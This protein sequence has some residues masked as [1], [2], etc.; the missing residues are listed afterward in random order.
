MERTYQTRRNSRIVRRLVLMHQKIITRYVFQGLYPA[1]QVSAWKALKR[2]AIRSH[3]LHH[4]EE[5]Q[6][7]IQ[8]AVFLNMYMDKI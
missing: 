8:F 5:R 1:I 3:R 7:T 6:R 2:S 4:L